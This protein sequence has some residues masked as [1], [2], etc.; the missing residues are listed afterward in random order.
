MSRRA[1]ELGEHGSIEVTPQKLI[2]GKWKRHPSGRGA[3]RYRARCYYRGFDGLMGECSRVA[4]SKPLALKA[5]AAALSEALS[6]GDGDVTAT[7][8]L[9]TAG[10]MWLVQIARRD[11]G[12]SARTISDY[13]ATLGRYVDTEGSSVRGLTLSQANDPQRIRAFL[14]TVADKHG[15]AAAKIAKTVLSGIIGQAVNDGVLTMNASRQVRP[16]KAQ[17]SKV[18]KT[19]RDTSRA[20]TRGERDAVMAYADGLVSKCAHAL[21]APRLDAD[22]KGTPGRHK[23]LRRVQATADLTAFMAGTG[24]RIG[25][26]RSLRWEHLD[27]DNGTADIHGTKSTSSRRLLSLPSWLVDRLVTRSQT[28]PDYGY[29]F[30]SPSGQEKMWDQS[31]SGK[32]VKAV[33]IGADFAWATPH[34]FRKTVV[35]SLHEAGVPLVQIADQ[36]GHAD[37]AMTARVYLGRDFMGDKSELAKHL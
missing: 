31:N 29:V 9:I 2:E 28:G 10:K 35:T 30:A 21:A 27:L 8:P 24:V 16:V 34:T 14:Q 26:A 15:T 13:T 37:P 17:V 11:S 32:Y 18:D 25:E 4:K 22:G 5:V 33:L 3:D 19:K 23:S 20:F 12:L 6:A 7:M 36:V 1:L